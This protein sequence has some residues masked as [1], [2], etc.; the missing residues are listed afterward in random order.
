MKKRGVRTPSKGMQ[1]GRPFGVSTFRDP[2]RRK[3][4]FRLSDRRR[5][6][7]RLPLISI[8]RS[9]NVGQIFFESTS[10]QIKESLTTSH[11]SNK[12]FIVNY[13]SDITQQAAVNVQ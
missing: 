7:F 5:A 1:Y 8:F 12:I 13:L 2:P 4:R 9:T 10:G 6:P 3:F 11:L